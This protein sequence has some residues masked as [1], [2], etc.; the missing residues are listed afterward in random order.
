MTLKDFKS[1]IDQAYKAAGKT[2]KTAKVEV[3]LNGETYAITRI[4]QF[5]VVRDVNI[6]IEK[7]GK[8]K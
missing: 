7:E 8:K 4:G 3:W 5:G 6:S 1:C 2:A